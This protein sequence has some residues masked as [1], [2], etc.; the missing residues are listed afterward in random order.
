M[1][2]KRKLTDKQARFCQ[3]YIKDLNKTQAAIRA[4]YSKNRAS[5][6]GYQLLQNPTVQAEIERLQEEIKEKNW[7]TVDFVLD[8]LK[9][10][11][12]KCKNVPVLDK[13]GN[14]VGYKIDSAGA[15]RALELMGK[16]IN[17]FVDRKEITHK[18]AYSD[19][20]IDKLLEEEDD[21]TS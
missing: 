14:L 16:H 20:E 7:L 9:E 6:L 19:Q 13:E 15:N 18:K 8:G 11:Y 12:E 5:E 10:V 21:Q 3:E 1:G 17:M 2:K 4:G